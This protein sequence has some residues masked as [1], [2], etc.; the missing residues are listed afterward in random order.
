MYFSRRQFMTS[1]AAAGLFMASRFHGL[2]HPAATEAPPSPCFLHTG[3]GYAPFIDAF[4]RQLRPGSDAFIAE[5]YAAEIQL[6]MDAWRDSL[7]S[8]PRDTSALQSTI[9]PALNATPL[10]AVVVSSVRNQLPVLSDVATYPAARQMSGAAFLDS[11]KTYFSGI[12]KLRTVELQIDGIEVLASDPLQVRTSIHFDFVGESSGP[13]REER[14]GEWEVAWQK[15]PAGKWRA[16]SWLGTAEK[17]SR[18]TG[19]G[20]VDITGSCFANVYSFDKQ[21]R[22]GLDYWRTVLD[23]ASG[24]DIYGNNGISVGDFDGDGFDDIYVCQPSGLPNRLYQNRGDGTFIDVTDRAGVGVLDGTSSAIFA[25]LNNNGHQDLIVVRTSGPLLFINR[26]D[27]TFELK[28]DAF[29]FARPPQGTFT[30]LAVADYDRNGL[31]DV[32]F[33]LYSYYQGLSEYEF[34]K[35][36]YDAQ[37]GPPNFL[38]KNRGDYS[39]EDVTVSSGIDQNNNRFSFACGWNDFDNDGW[40]DLYVVNDFG[41][42][43]LYRNK[44]DGTFTDVSEQAGVEDPG[45]GM[46]VCWF[47]YDNDGFE[48]LY[49]ANM[50][51]AAGKRI[52]TQNAFLP[53]APESSRQTYRKHANGNSL[54]HNSSGSGSFTNATEESGTRLGRWSW[55]S[56]AWDFDHDGYPD[57]YVANGFISGPRADNLSSFFWRQIVARSLANGGSSKDYA[58]AWSAINEFI[59]SDHSWSGYQRNNF[60]LNNRNGSFVEAAGVLGLDFLDDSRSFALAD[61]DND[62]RLEVVLKNRT[63][64]QIRVLHNELNPLASTIIFSLRGTKGNR[65]A[66]GAV[67]ELETSQGKQ[68]NTVRAGSGFLAQHSKALCFGLGVDSASVRATITWPSGT[69]TVYEALP[70]GHRIE[71]EEGGPGFKS[72]S[73]HTTRTPSETRDAVIAPGDQ[74]AGSDTWLVDP[75]LAPGFTLKDAHGK[76]YSLNESGGR[77][78]LLVFWKSDCGQS[79]RQLG[80]IQEHWKEWPQGELRV[81][82]VCVDE[83]PR[84]ETANEPASGSFPFPALQ[85]DKNTRGIYN[86]FHR[87]LFE[88]RQDMMLPTSFL[89]DRD[90]AAIKVYSGMA[91]P[92]RILKDAAAAP[93]T[94]KDRLR[95]A[96]P[97]DGRYF[98]SGLHHNYFTYGVAFLQY[99]YLDQALNSFQ[100]AI[101][102]NPGYAASYYNVGL[103]FLNK[104]NFEE[105]KASLLKAV[106]LNPANADA[107][108]NLGVIHGQQADY[109]QAARDFQ[110][111]V[112][113]QPTHVLALQNL[114]KLYRFQGKLD[115][116]Q[117]LLESGVA[118]DPSVP[119]LHYGL[120]MLLVER[121]Q[122][123]QA[124]REFEI[125]VQLQ[126][127]NAEGLNGLGVVLMQMGD[128]TQAMRRFE[129]CRLVAPD[130]DRPYL[131]MAVLYMSAGQRGKAHDL[132]S[133][134]L[135]TQPGNQEVREAL[136]EVDSGQ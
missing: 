131:N 38:F 28:P 128:S 32:Y 63:A 91:D 94:A 112:A 122:L 21:M 99:G 62:G 33:C 35:P 79:Q 22:S 109:N 47:D 129:D 104:S 75:I 14:T 59:R 83:Q 78:T 61:L 42:K 84:V 51:S 121:K 113:L 53:A 125:L 9:T 3:S 124:V 82:S 26:G 93:L 117:V 49:V 107:W 98:G 105:A 39:F 96:L 7:L 52:S 56:D 5:T 118:A 15:D 88:R 66:I 54:F 72:V 29:R 57:L 97:F 101:A 18:L 24:I 80:A 45:A 44:G 133:Q 43:N 30:A 89:I 65:D 13:Q 40:P 126:P 120:G 34:P 55:S 36:Y 2:P 60:Y 92:A 27:G 70:P 17:R 130:F 1:S 23:G 114:V 95:R 111:T 10:G 134:Y 102:R 85:S 77:L 81:L 136:K 19:P 100:E 6:L 135:E 58:D 12:D 119:E 50:W 16:Q 86:I 108:N 37:N 46:S 132:L 103:I 110:K 11:L 116:A 4:L 115:Q 64:P 73:F 71:I 20:F 48:D 87:Y 68:R 127:D 76:E 106:E 41:R 123:P 31:L 74:S 90:G 25:D 69:K 8:S 67:I